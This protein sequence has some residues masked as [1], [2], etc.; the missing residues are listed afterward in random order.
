MSSRRHPSP[1]LLEIRN[2][3]QMCPAAGE[4]EPSENVIHDDEYLA[5]IGNDKDND[6]Q[7]IPNH[8]EQLSENST[9]MSKRKTKRNFW[10]SSLEKKFRSTI[11]T[12]K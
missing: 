8:R 7:D 1:S 6:E 2:S 9:H 3:A 11:L 5:T 10:F 4:I 12:S